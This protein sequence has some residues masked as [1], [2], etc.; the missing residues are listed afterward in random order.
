MNNQTS[1]R[2]YNPDEAKE[3]LRASYLRIGRLPKLNRGTIVHVDYCGNWHKARLT[4][5]L[6]GACYMAVLVSCPVSSPMVTVSVRNFGGV[7][8]NA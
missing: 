7:V 5:G 3:L 6:P 8:E 2:D 1:T 4:R